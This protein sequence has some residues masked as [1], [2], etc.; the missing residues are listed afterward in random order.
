LF[1]YKIACNLN[2]FKLRQICVF[3][4]KKNMEIKKNI[5]L[6][7]MMG[8]GK[9]TIGSLLAK[10]LD[11]VLIDIDKVIEKMQNQKISQIFELKGEAYF[12]ELEFNITT[13]FLNDNDKLISLGGGAFM[14]KE[15]RKIIKQN[16]KSFWLHW[17]AK[18]LIKRIKNNDKRPIV[19]N[20]NQAEI[21]KLINERNKIYYFADFKIICENLK[22]SEIVDRI[23]QKCEKNEIVY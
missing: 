6:L 17:N 7:G 11:R 2:N 16:S 22:K 10:K 9:S 12:R 14:N 1:F 13:Q 4:I 3:S 20:M 21:K 23:L 18:T 19:K 15:L 5:V 8:S